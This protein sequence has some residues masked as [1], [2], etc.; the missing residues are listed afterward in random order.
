[1]KVRKTAV[2][3]PLPLASEPLRVDAQLQGDI[4]VLVNH[5]VVYYMF[6]VFFVVTGKLVDV[7]ST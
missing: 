4:I 2:N 6:Q 1:M 5:H 3:T 7:K